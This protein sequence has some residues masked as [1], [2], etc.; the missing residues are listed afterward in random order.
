MN[1]WAGKTEADGEER[2]DSL[3]RCHVRIV[4][5]LLTLQYEGK[6]KHLLR[7]IRPTYRAEWPSRREIDCVNDQGEGEGSSDFS[8]ALLH[9]PRGGMGVRKQLLDLLCCPA[10]SAWCSGQ[11]GG[12]PGSLSLSRTML[13][14]QCYRRKSRVQRVSSVP[15]I[16]MLTSH[17]CWWRW[18][19]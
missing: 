4:V 2:S 9:L 10:S 5:P 6:S 18:R 15:L 11:R 17:P 19:R 16:A 1:S 13:M 14:R 3:I 7:M 12:S 8:W